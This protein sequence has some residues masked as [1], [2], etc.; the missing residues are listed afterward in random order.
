[1]EFMHWDSSS[2]RREAGWRTVNV[3]GQALPHTALMGRDFSGQPTLPDSTL[4]LGIKSTKLKVR[5]LGLTKSA[6]AVHFSIADRNYVLKSAGAYG[7]VAVQR[8]DVQ[9]YFRQADDVV[10][11]YRA[12][13][14]STLGTVEG[15]ADATDLAIALLFT[16]V[17][18]YSFTAGMSTFVGSLKAVGSLLQPGGDGV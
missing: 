12:Q 10:D 1:M 8:E 16:E 17:D 3:E 5:N 4:R 13:R 15:P 7:N 11:C 9:V 18:T 6:R 2:P 14:K